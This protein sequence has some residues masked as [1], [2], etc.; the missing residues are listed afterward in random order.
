[1]G[2]REEAQGGGRTTGREPADKVQGG[3]EGGRSQGG[4]SRTQAT[5]ITAA[6]GGADSG[7]SH[8]G[9]VADDSRGPANGGGTGG[10]GA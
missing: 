2:T 3:D 7:R 9:G 4:D 8:G 5:A 1:M 10:G 6:H